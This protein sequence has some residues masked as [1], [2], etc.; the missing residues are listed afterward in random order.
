MCMRLVLCTRRENTWLY[1]N[2]SYDFVFSTIGQWTENSAFLYAFNLLY[3]F[4]S[5][6]FFLYDVLSC[7]QNMN[8]RT[9]PLRVNDTDRKRHRL[10]KREWA[11]NISQWNILNASQ[12]HTL[13]IQTEFI[14]ARKLPNLLSTCKAHLNT[15]LLD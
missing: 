1:C 10:K 4:G 15:I 13:W 11:R 14:Y 12:F 7:S 5:H 6:N 2:W 8:A 9:G 3:V